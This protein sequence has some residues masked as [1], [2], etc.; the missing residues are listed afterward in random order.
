MEP[1]IAI[2]T[3]N[4]FLFCPRSLYMHLAAGDISPASYQD[5]PQTNGNA[6]HATTDEKRYSNHASVLQS[7]DIYCESLGIQGKLDVFDTETGALTER[8]ARL[9]QIHEG[10]LM[11]L[12][13]EYYC[14]RD[15]G[16]HPKKLAFYSIEDNKRYPVKLP[17]KENKLRLEEIITEM[18]NYTTAKLLKHRCAHCNDN[19]YA[20]LTW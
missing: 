19:I 18:Q 1:L 5:T 3:I 7:M 2:S 20:G 17:T 11:Q 12:Y 9:K 15:M 4:D 13:A 14:L 6:A 16:Y 8:K 10:Y